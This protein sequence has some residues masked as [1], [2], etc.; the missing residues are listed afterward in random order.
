MTENL[1]PLRGPAQRPTRLRSAG[2]IG[3]AGIAGVAMGLGATS[4]ALWNDD[5]SFTG[6]ISSGYE[7]F[8]AGLAGGD[9]TTASSETAP[10]EGDSVT[11]TVGAEEAQILAETGKL[12]VVGQ[13]KPLT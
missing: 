12:A 2:V 7:Y 13:Y 11:V 3:V 6:S 4:L 8:A 9:L 5:V 1:T 10:P